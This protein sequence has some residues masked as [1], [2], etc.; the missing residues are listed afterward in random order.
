MAFAGASPAAKVHRNRSKKHAGEARGQGRRAGLRGGAPPS[1]RGKGRDCSPC[2]PRRRS[3][4]VPAML[5]RA[6]PQL[7]DPPPR[8]SSRGDRARS[9]R[10][11]LPAWS[12]LQRNRNRR[13]V[14]ASGFAT[15]GLRCWA[16]RSRRDAARRP[17]RR[18]R[19]HHVQRRKH[20]HDPCRS[21][22][23]EHPSGHSRLVRQRQCARRLILWLPFQPSVQIK[24]TRC[25]ATPLILNPLIHRTHSILPSRAMDRA[26]AVV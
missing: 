2:S 24:S 19:M 21:P 5:S 23:G 4:V 7:P 13:I 3:L 26:S 6:A 20:W 22:P 14:R 15:G 18:R 1:G 12:G 9:E 17:R 11:Q 10:C 16:G 8:G 25:A